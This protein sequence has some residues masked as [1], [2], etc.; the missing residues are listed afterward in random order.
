M[1]MADDEH[2]AAIVRSTVDLGHRLGLRVIA[3]GVET[4]AAWELLTEFACDE[5]QGHFLM[6]PV[7]GEV[8]ATWLRLISRPSA[9]TT[10]GQAWLVNRL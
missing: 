4:Q 5:A 10:Q 9:I 8:L 2:D 7:P 1:R 6:Q 3:E